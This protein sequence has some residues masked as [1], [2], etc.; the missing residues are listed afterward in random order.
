MRA[1]PLTYMLEALRAPLE[2]REFRGPGR[3]RRFRGR[4]L[5]PFGGRGRPQDRPERRVKRALLLVAIAALAG[6]SR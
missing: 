3:D 5:R 4:L 2:G 1:N 6:C